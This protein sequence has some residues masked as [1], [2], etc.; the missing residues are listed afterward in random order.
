MAKLQRSLSDENMMF[1]GND[2]DEDDLDI[3]NIFDTTLIVD[4]KTDQNGNPANE[5]SQS[6]DDVNNTKRRSNEQ[7]NQTQTTRRRNL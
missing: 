6:E 3:R 7:E 5:I 1:L 2:F 4:N